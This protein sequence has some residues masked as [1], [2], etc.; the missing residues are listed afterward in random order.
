[1]IKADK[2]LRKT[3]NRGFPIYLPQVDK[4]LL[5]VFKCGYTSSH[6]AYSPVGKVLRSFNDLLD[7][8]DTEKVAL[9]RSPYKRVASLWTC[10]NNRDNLHL[11]SDSF[12]K[13]VKNIE[14][15]MDQGFTDGHYNSITANLTLQGEFMAD[16]VFDI[17]QLGEMVEYLGVDVQFPHKNE[18]SNK[19]PWQS[20][21]T[22]ESKALV[23][24]LHKADFGRFNYTFGE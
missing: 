8:P 16:K 9:I 18:S 11:Y 23:E 24:K 6:A 1:M 22:D 19:K 17:S 10:Q 7:Y 20:Y 13:F 14:I 5:P 4:I 21:Y 3:M 15:L 2:P 12:D